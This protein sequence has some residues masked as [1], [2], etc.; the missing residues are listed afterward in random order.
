MKFYFF[1]QRQRCDT[2]VLTLAKNPSLLA[3]DLGVCIEICME[4]SQYQVYL[5]STYQ[6]IQKYRFYSMYDI[7]DVLFGAC[8]SSQLYFWSDFTFL[9][10]RFEKKNFLDFHNPA[11]SYLS[12]TFDRTYKLGAP[13]TQS[14]LQPSMTYPR[15]LFICILL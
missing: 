2:P 10:P 13:S 14:R 15:Q 5:E 8:L 7:F 12:F 11:L 1:N 4:I 6:C 3:Q 9:I